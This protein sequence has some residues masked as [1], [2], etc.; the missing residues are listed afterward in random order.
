VKRLPVVVVAGRDGALGDVLSRL[1]SEA[2]QAL[3]EGRIFIGARRAEKPEERVAAGVEVAMYPAREPSGP[4]P[5]ILLEERGIVAAYKPAGIA[6]VAD[7]RGSTGTLKERVARLAGIPEGR[8]AVTS[9]LDVG[10]SGV[11]LFATDEASRARLARA[12]QEGRYLRHYVAIASRSPAP[13]RGLWKVPIGKDRDARKRRAF[14]REAVA[15]STAYAVRAAVRA[16][17]LLAVEPRTGRTHQIRVH[18]AHAGCALYGDATYGGPVKTISKDGRVSAFGRIALHAAWVE[19]PGDR[20]STLRVEAEIPADLE[21]I[22]T[23]CGGEP[24]AWAGALE[25]L[26]LE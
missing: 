20:S 26:E 16:A 19:V 18:A 25:R 5:R 4:S 13:E 9:R 14:G 8:L 22:W 17:A 7:H 21:A 6:S 15:A 3:R 10:V 11:V 24:S 2:S 1:G 23:A 12:R